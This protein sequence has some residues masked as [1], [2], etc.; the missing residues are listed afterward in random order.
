MKKRAENKDIKHDGNV[1]RRYCPNRDQRVK[2]RK[3]EFTSYK[4]KPCIICNKIKHKGDSN[5]IRVCGRRSAQQLLS[6]TRFFKDDV[7]TKC[8]LLECPGDV[9]AENILYRKTC[10][11]SYIQKFKRELE[12]IM[13]D[14]EDIVDYSVEAMF[15]DVIKALNL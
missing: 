1:R 8:V 4:E 6:A 13:M 3:I 7:H 12:L 10:M 5:R 2:R 9:F 15:N 14:D 11:S